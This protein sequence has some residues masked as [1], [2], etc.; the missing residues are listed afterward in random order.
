TEGQVTDGWAHNLFVVR[1][2]VLR[3]P[4]LSSGAL[5][6]VVRDTV[7]TLAREA[8]IPT[9]EEILVRTDL[10]HADECFLTGTAAGI[11]PVVGVDRR[12]VAAGK[13][14]PVTQQ[15]LSRYA[16]VITGRTSDHPEWRELVG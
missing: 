7:L 3:T 9:R 16:D 4:S 1:D 11:V 2:G 6:G 14:G 13:V 10:Y 15:L 5:E 8:G 12:P